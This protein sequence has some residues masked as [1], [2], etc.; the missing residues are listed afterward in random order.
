MLLRVILKII[1]K[2]ICECVFCWNIRFQN[3]RQSR[4]ACWEFRE[5]KRAGRL[6]ADE[7]DAFAVLRNHALGIDD[8]GKKLIPKSF[9]EIP[10]DHVEGVSP[11]VSQQVLYIFKNER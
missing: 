10:S 1:P 3:L 11:I 7:E 6:K 9:C 4:S 8:F 5:F 2:V